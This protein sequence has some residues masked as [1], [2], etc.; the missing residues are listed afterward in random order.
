MAWKRTASVSRDAN[1]FFRS[2][3]SIVNYDSGP[4]AETLTIRVCVKYVTAQ[5][6]FCNR[7]TCELV[8]LVQSGSDLVE[9][10]GRGQRREH[11]VL[12]AAV[13]LFPDRQSAEWR[14][15]RHG[16]AL[17]GLC[18]WLRVPFYSAPG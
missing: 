2:A 18:F 1:L 3:V 5:C 13:R 14:A 4:A 7:W 6:E 12:A 17:R 10:S 16:R 15:S 9:F 11:R 8:G